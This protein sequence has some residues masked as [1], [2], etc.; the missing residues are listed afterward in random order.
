VDEG[1]EEGGANGFG[2]SERY[3]S[4]SGYV[5]VD[6]VSFEW[7]RHTTPFSYFMLLLFVE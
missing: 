3:G 5:N 6:A 4:G 7:K 1:E 2:C